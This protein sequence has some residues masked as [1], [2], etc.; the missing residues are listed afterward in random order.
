MQAPMTKPVRPDRNITVSTNFV[1]YAEPG[2]PFCFHNRIPLLSFYLNSLY[3][4]EN[5]KLSL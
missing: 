1:R 4:R 2:D 3:V 5:Y